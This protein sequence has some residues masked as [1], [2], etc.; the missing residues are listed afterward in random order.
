MVYFC[1]GSL[2]WQGLQAATEEQKYSDILQKMMSTSIGAL[3]SG[4][5]KEFALY[6]KYCRSLRFYDKPDYS[7]LRR[8]FRERFV[9]EGFEDD[10]AL[11]WGMNKYQQKTQASVQSAAHSQ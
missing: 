8:I 2:P 5:P 10:G 9:Q 4:I 7:Y 6:L 1:R 11:D 3:C